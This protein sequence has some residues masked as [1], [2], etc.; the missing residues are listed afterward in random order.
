MCK[1]TA[2]WLG[3]GK[4][5]LSLFFAVFLCANAWSNGL[6]AYYAFEENADDSSGNG[7]NGLVTGAVNVGG[8]YQGRCYQFDGVDDYI[9]I[10]HDDLLGSPHFTFTAWVRS[11]QSPAVGIRGIFGKHRCYDNYHFY[12]LVQES[13]ILR[14]TMRGDVWGWTDACSAPQA[15]LND[16]TFV[17]LT[18]DGSLMKLNVNGSTVAS[19][20]VPGYQGNVYDM[21]IGAQEWSFYDANTPQWLWKGLIDEVRVYDCALSEE[22]LGILYGGET[23]VAPSLGAIFCSLSPTGAVAAGAAWRIASLESDPWH[24]SGEGV[25]SLASGRYSLEFKTLDSW[26]A[27][28]S[29][30]LD[31][32]PGMTTAVSAVYTRPPNDGLILY[33]PF[34]E[35]EGSVVVDQS[36]CGNSGTVYGATFTPSGRQG[37]ALYFDGLSNFIRVVD[38]D[39]LDC[40]QFTLSAWVK[41]PEVSVPCLNDVRGIVGKHRCG[42]NISFN[43][44]YTERGE[45]KNMMVGS[46]WGCL[47]YVTNSAAPISNQWGLVT[48]TYDGTVVN[49]YV[50]GVLVDQELVTG[51]QGNGYDLLIGAGEW[52]YPSGA[53][54]QYWWYGWIDEFRMYNYA[55]SASQVLSL[56]G[57]SNCVPAPG[58]VR[59]SLGPSN[60]VAAGAA[61]KLTSEG[62][63]SWH[64]AG[65]V[66][67]NLTAGTYTL[68][69]KAIDGWRKPA[70]RS[71]VI[72]SGQQTETEALYASMVDCGL[73]VYFPFDQDEGA[74]VSDQSGCGN[75]G[76]VFGATCAAEGRFGG[77]FQFDGISDYIRVFDS[78][79]LDSTQFTVSAWVKTSEAWTE[80]PNGVRGI[81]GK[82]QI[83][84]N[85]SF[86]WLYTEYS[87]L[88]AMMVGS[89]YGN[90]HHTISDVDSISNTW[91]MVTLTYDGAAM[92]LYVN[93]ML[94]SEEAVSGYVGNGYDLLVGAGEWSGYNTDPRRFWDGWI[95]EFRVYNY[96]MGDADVARLYLGAEAVSS[97]GA[98]ACTMSPSAVLA[99]GAGWRLTSEAGASWHSSGDVVSS[100]LSGVYTVAFKQVSGWVAPSNRSVYVMGNFT[101]RINGAYHL[102]PSNELVVYFN[103]DEDEGNTITDLSGHGNSGAVHSTTYTPAGY[104]GGAFCFNSTSSYIQVKDSVSMDATQFTV[105][106]WVKTPE[107][108]VPSINGLCG[109]AGKHR[110]GDNVSFYWLYT[111]F[112]ELKGMMVG[113][114]S[115]NLHHTVDGI[116]AIS[117]I[118]GMVTLTY[119]GSW[120]RLYINGSLVDENAL[121]GYTGNSHDLLVGAG[122]W[123]GFNVSPQRFWDGWIDEFRIYNYAMDSNEVLA[124][125]DS[126]TNEIVAGS[127]RC[128]IHPPQAVAQGAGWALSS[129]APPVWKAGSDVIDG[130]TP[131]AYPIT[132]K[133]VSGWTKPDDQTVTV[134]GGV[135]N[136]GDATYRIAPTNGLILYYPFSEDT[137][138]VI[139]DHSGYGNSGAVFNAAFAID[140]FCGRAV[141][142]NGTSSYIRVP[143]NELLNPTQFTVSVWAKAPSARVAAEDEI[144]GMVGKYASG[145]TGQV[146]WLCTATNTLQAGMAGSSADGFR[147]ANTVMNSISNRWGM[148][149]LT[150]DGSTMKLYVDGILAGEEAVSGYEGNELDLL[151]GAGQWDGLSETAPQRWWD[152]WIDEVRLYNRALSAAEVFGQYQNDAVDFT[153]PVILSIQPANGFVT[154][155][156]SVNLHVNVTDNVGVTAVLINGDP[157]LR[158]TD[159][160]WA[161]KAKLL[162]FGTNVLDVVASDAAGNSVTQ[163]VGYV[164]GKHLKLHAMADGLWSVENKNDFDQ[165]F[166]WAVVGSTES[167][168]GLAL[169][170]G[171]TTFETSTG[172]KTVRLYADGVLQDTQPWTPK[173]MIQCSMSNIA[174]NPQPQSLK[175]RLLGDSETSGVAMR[176]GFNTTSGQVYRVWALTNLCGSSRG[177]EIYCTTSTSG[178]CA[179]DLQIGDE[180]MKFMWAT[181]ENIATNGF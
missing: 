93:G 5:V 89:D 25:G 26:V 96:A 11:D 68:T 28:S 64:D 121:T 140:G 150:F 179:F 114:D 125:H 8:G 80:A 172:P 85:Y 98:I 24:F 16:W 83:G 42:D 157:A 48:I 39:M 115:G 41:A 91:G 67:S 180:P 152:G 75:D 17:G 1:I 77:A 135:T 14:G 178:Q 40:P 63:D 65:A 160:R 22:S 73:V 12:S 30:S 59:C 169:A 159:T 167:G 81:A 129:E 62:E 32:L 104:R 148:V 44:L 142:F 34:D 33:Y 99:A 131:G 37:G 176:L 133:E 92:R 88:K 47:Q 109:I 164:K 110:I 113:S 46:S 175:Q 155:A 84:A 35:D 117:N 171:D 120:M 139:V 103:F 56:Y 102:I 105:S 166:E 90:L 94:K 108:R 53:S 23:N 52:T 74:W 141:L 70:D 4:F 78:A 3:P 20:S 181:V 49:M 124:L 51:Y 69:F 127:L 50:N 138:N 177:T 87:A 144:R 163:R 174:S 168:S 111:E 29:V 36:G 156:G 126:F 76:Q 13:D 15:S 45:L 66:L 79:T 147:T 21:I 107:E 60:A 58:S 31:L 6:V 173:P 132:F 82:H 123:S 101:N 149:T 118:W 95:D 158:Q 154:V 100:L 2:S 43:W 112:S 7:L 18:Y 143:H 146:Y 97:T 57:G 151:I 134:L 122:E 165:P 9:V 10:P 145:E 55:L 136:A 61:W 86:Y 161:Y 130:L 119:D 19:Q 38:N 71:V 162:E 128:E 27:P 137:G 153:A 170:V 72:L 106:A 54:P 116:E